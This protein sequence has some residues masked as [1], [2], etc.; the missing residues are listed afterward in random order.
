MYRG[1]KEEEGSPAILLAVSLLPALQGPG[2]VGRGERADAGQHHLLRQFRHVV[3]AADLRGQR[4][5]AL[6]ARPPPG[7]PVLPAVMSPK[8]TAG[9]RGF[10]FLA[11]L[12]WMTA[13]NERRKEC[14]SQ[15]VVFFF[16]VFL[17]YFILLFFISWRLITLQYCSGFCHMYVLTS[18]G[19]GTNE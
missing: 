7:Q 19:Q 6:G 16:K 3:K 13:E 17:F 9:K 18:L 5:A 11:K 12:S 10:K 4:L 14:C 1:L 8:A 15:Y 2:A